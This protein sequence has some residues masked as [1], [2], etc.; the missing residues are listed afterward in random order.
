MQRFKSS[1][2]AQRFL[3]AFDLIRQHFHPKQHQLSAKD[4]RQVMHQRFKSWQQV[5]CIYPMP[6]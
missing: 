1:D 5:T 3:A 6:V 2:Q 4:Y